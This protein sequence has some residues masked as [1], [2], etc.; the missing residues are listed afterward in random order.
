MSGLFLAYGAM[1]TN[2]PFTGGM[3]GGGLLAFIIG[4]L[5]AS[6]IVGVAIW[7][8]T[9]F[10]YMVIARKLRQKS[11]GLAWIPFVGPI[12]ISYKASKMHWWPW[13]LLIG[14]L[15]PMIGWIA[16]IVF[17]VYAAIW[18]WKMLELIKRPGWWAVV[19][20]L[21]IIPIVG[22]VALIVYLILIG[23]AAWSRN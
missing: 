9:S 10:A 8:Y 22:F 12:I 5:V 4:A 18:T 7:V 3:I 19:G 23:I 6:L 20:A 2:N 13:L 16:I 14:I 17:T 21:S 15:I 11:P 1:M